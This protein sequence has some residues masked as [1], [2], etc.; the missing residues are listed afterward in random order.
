MTDSTGA[1]TY[2]LSDGVS[3][4]ASMESGLSMYIM[5]V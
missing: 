1:F 2:I 4:E 3:F 5:K